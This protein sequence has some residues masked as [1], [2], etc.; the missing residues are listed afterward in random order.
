M[1]I[2]LVDDSPIFLAVIGELL[3]LEPGMEVVGQARSGLEALDQAALLHPDLVLMDLAMPGMDGLEA[4]RLIKARP[5]PPRIIILTL[6]DGAQYRYAAAQSNADGC[7]SKAEC[8]TG[9]PC[10]LAKMA[11]QVCDGA[12]SVHTA[13]P[14]PE[15]ST[16]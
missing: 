16:L 15:V 6:D 11:A 9:Q 13:L 2:L 8:A 12:R 7:L 5:N 10:L 14:H 1:R 4:T 3:N